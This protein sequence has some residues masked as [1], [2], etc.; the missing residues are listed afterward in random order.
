M[1][2]NQ[3]P[4]VVIIACFFVVFFN[5]AP[6]L[7]VNRWV[8]QWRFKRFDGITLTGPGFKMR[9][10]EQNHHRFLKVQWGTSFSSYNN[11]THTTGENHYAYSIKTWLWF[12]VTHNLSTDK[13]Q[14]ISIKYSIKAWIQSGC[15]QLIAES[16][17]C[18]SEA[19]KRPLKIKRSSSSLS[20]W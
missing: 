4:A 9:V 16:S 10:S 6:L 19:T 8:L 12:P 13:W 5:A 15:V 1:A 20:F 3:T 11:Y 7:R 18:R 14:N 17:H 2:V